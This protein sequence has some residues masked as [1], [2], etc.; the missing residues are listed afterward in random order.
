MQRGRI[1]RDLGKE[2]DGPLEA[3]ILG[4]RSKVSAINAAFI[5]G[6]LI[7]TLDY[8]ALFGIHLPPF[9]IPAPLALAEKVRMIQIGGATGRI[10]PYDMVDTPL[11]FET[12]LGAGAI[13]VCDES[14]DVLDIVYRTMEFLA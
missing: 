6:E 7:S 11:A 8:D 3:T 10:I 9:V 1:C 12:I 14:R 13:M 4:A 2:L 5:N